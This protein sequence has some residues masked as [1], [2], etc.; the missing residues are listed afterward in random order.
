[1]ARQWLR[2]VSLIVGP[3]SGEGLDLGQFRISF[4]V[5]QWDVQTPNTLVARVYNLSRDTANRIKGEFTRVVLRAGYEGSFGTIFAGNIKQVRRGRLSATDSYIE[6][7]AGEGDQAYNWSV[8]NSSVAA[9]AGPAE[10]IEAARQALGQ[11]GVEPGYAPALEGPRYPR[12]VAQFGMARDALTEELDGLSMSWSIRQDRCE[13][14]PRDSYLP[15]E[16][17]AINSRTGM[18]GVPEQ[19]ED[20]ISLRAL[21]NP[22]LRIGGRI[23]LDNQS[24]TDF[25]PDLRY[26]AINFP[27]QISDNGFYKLLV[28]EHVGDTHGQEWYSEMVCIAV[29]GTVP[30][31]QALRGR[32]G[33]F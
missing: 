28:V 30:I 3:E 5:G 1:M 21:L 31:G 4:R 16:A 12:G 26:T 32:G 19:T 23:Q 8:V 24:I 13:I 33:E 20:G 7:Y 11:Y 2:K 6:I 29:D 22:N 25:R 27:S 18:I 15:G 9:G 17:I 14:I 10:R